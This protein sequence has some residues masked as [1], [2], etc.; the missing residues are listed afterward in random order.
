MLTWLT[1]AGYSFSAVTLSALLE[2]TRRLAGGGDLVE[3]SS[4]LLDTFLD[5]RQPAWM[6]WKLFFVSKNGDK[7]L[8]FEPTRQRLV[9]LH[10]Q[11]KSQFVL[12]AP[13][14]PP[15]SLPGVPSECLVKLRY[16]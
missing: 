5:Q 4:V 6:C 12:R 11:Q 8:N 15:S 3:G 2:S 10:C 13:L 14:P 16:L 7:E 1:E 9:R